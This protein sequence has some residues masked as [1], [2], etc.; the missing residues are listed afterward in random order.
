M[1][2]REN[3]KKIAARRAVEYVKDGM[4]VGLGS[5]TTAAYAIRFLGER[6]EKEALKILGVATSKASKELAVSVGIPLVTN[7]EEFQLDLAIDGTDRVDLAGRLIKGGGG[8][9]LHER[10]VDGAADRFFVVGD[11]SK[12]VDPIG[13]QPIVIPVEVFSLGW[14]NTMRRL[15]TLGCRAKL[16]YIND[17]TPSISDEGNYTIDCR[18]DSF[19][20]PLKLANLIRSTIG[21]ADHGIFIGMASHIII[22]KD[23]QIEEFTIHSSLQENRSIDKS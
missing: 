18:F 8:A 17:S 19:D 2:D 21:V 6:I 16:R 12:L 7:L 9:L 15:E 4:K 23:T 10:I 14:K 11:S 22:A 13:S 3:E 1:S 20:D 5:G